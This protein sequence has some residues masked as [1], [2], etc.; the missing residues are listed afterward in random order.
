MPKQTQAHRSAGLKGDTQAQNIACQILN[1]AQKS[2]NVSKLSKHF[3]Q[4]L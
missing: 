3:V 1:K 4:K 2:E